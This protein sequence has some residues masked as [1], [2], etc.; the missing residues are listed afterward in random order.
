MSSLRAQA[1]EVS[2]D[3]SPPAARF[4]QPAAMAAPM[5][6]DY[7]VVIL[8]ASGVGK[9]CLGLRFVKDQF[10]TY[11]AST[12]GASFLVKELAFNN[13]KVTLQ[14]WDTAGQERFQSLGVAFYRGADS[15]VLVFDVVQP[16]TFDN[17]DSWRDEFLIQVSLRCLLCTQWQGACVGSERDVAHMLT[18]CTNFVS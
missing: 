14:I 9:T 7:K 1:K 18:W 10:V 12:I 6:Q 4:L 3:R 8:G 11:T 13:Q 16:K 17:L 2:E 5:R 15:C